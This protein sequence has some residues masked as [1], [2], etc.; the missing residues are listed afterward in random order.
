M[1]MVDNFEAQGAFSSDSEG[2]CKY[3]FAGLKCI[4]GH[5]LAD[6]HYNEYFDLN[7][8]SVVN[9]IVVCA[10]NNSFHDAGGK[11][12]LDIPL[13]S[14]LQS[15]HDSP[16]N[17]NVAGVALTADKMRRTIEERLG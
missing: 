15:L 5:G 13:L 16:Y 3:R 7:A 10:M 9:D 6:E 1:K 14:Q 11:S 12:D 17:Q 2:K 8:C 4:A